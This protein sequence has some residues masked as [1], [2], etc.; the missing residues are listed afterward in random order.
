[1][2]SRRSARSDRSS[3]AV[4]RRRLTRFARFGG[5]ATG[6]AGDLLLNGAKSLA[7]GQRPDLRKLLLT[8]SN[9]ERVTDELAR[10]RGA[11][12]KLGQ[13]LSMDAS[14]FLPP[15]LAEILAR[16][17]SDADAMPATQLRAALDDAW[18][19]GWRMRFENFDMAPIAAASIGQVHRAQARDGRDMAIKIQYPG[20]R[21]SIDSDVDNVATLIRLSG[22]LPADVDIEIFLDEAKRQLHDEADYHREGAYLH[23]FG[24]LLAADK[25]YAL[26]TLYDDL[27]TSTTLA[28]SYVGG[29]PIESFDRAPQAL[30]NRIVSLLIKLMFRELFDFRLMQTDP[31]FANYQYDADS[32]KIVLLDF[33]A[34]RDISASLVEGYRTLLAA[35]YADDIPAVVDAAVKI[36]FFDAATVDAHG[37]VITEMFAASMEPIRIKGPYDFG[38]SD[39]PNRLRDLGLAL[40]QEDVYGHVPPTETLFLQRKFAG[41]FMLANRLG[42][43]AHVRRLIKP[44]L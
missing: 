20:V 35:A 32:K 1:M 28:M 17:R 18:G 24:G 6:I 23:K 16:L 41:V 4:P 9:A 29:A 21:D 5:L 40:S 31:N 15:E 30:R 34:S 42:A 44:F 38:A 3:A 7:Q 37:A 36:G 26:P 2:P 14:D 43:T 33:G 19:V 27:T 39:L 25:D 10:L 11:A 12:M 8:P 13:L 22:L